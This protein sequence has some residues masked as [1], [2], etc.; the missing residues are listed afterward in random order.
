MIPELVDIYV[1]SALEGVEDLFKCAKT[2]LGIVAVIVNVTK[3]ADLLVG[4]LRKGYLA[5][6]AEVVEVAVLHLGV[7]DPKGAVSGLIE[8]DL[9]HIRTVAN[10]NLV[11]CHSV[12]G[13]VTS[14]L[15]AVCGNDDTLGCI[16]HKVKCHSSV[17]LYFI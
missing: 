11:S 10:C 1:A 15:A 5:L 16:F 12:A 17:S 9:D 6:G 2:K 14:A 13:N 4:K 7:E 8:V 3:L